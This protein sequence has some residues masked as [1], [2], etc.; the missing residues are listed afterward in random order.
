MK[1]RNILL[2]LCAVV[3]LNVV[4]A[5][6]PDSML[7]R[8]AARMLMVGFRGDSITEE[9]DAARYV[10]DL[11]VGGI[12]LFDIDLTGSAKIGS[13]NITEKSRLARLTADLRREAHRNLLIAIDQ[14]G[15]TVRRL[16]PE[17]GFLPAVSAEYLGKI[18]NRDTTFAHAERIAAEMDEVGLNV[19]L[20]PSVDVNVNP[21]CPVVGALHRSFSGD[22]A[23]VVQ[24]ATWTIEAHRCHGVLCALKHF[25]G[26]GSSASDSHYGLTDVTDTW[27]PYELAP[28][29]KLIRSGEV[30]MIMTAHIFNR[31]IDPDYPATLSKIFIDGILRRD[32]GFDGVVLTD[33]MYMQGIIDNYSVEDAIV[34]AINAGADMIVA[35]NNISTGYEPERP[36]QLVDM[37]VEAV[38]DGRIPI[39]RL[40]ESNR[41][42]DNLMKKLQTYIPANCP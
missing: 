8:C 16:R 31:K 35:G 33:D 7:R 22:T 14:E 26:H 37:I 27:Q 41:R 18:N 42:I 40:L 13:R 5:E 4:S 36:F 24:N 3:A 11:G 38:K 28:F 29:R 15:G 19:N 25:P 12:I 9:S 39:E 17:Y 6:L 32:L 2:S 21:E 10:R 23:V 1:I 30:D 34:L 20:A